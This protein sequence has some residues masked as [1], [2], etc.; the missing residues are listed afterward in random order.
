MEQIHRNKNTFL[1]PF[2]LRVCVPLSPVRIE[3]MKLG[4]SDSPS[5]REGERGRHRDYGRLHNAA[6]AAIAIAVPGGAVG[7]VGWL[8]QIGSRPHSLTNGH[9][10]AYHCHHHAGLLHGHLRTAMYKETK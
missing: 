6:F 2:N 10:D 7:P 9:F 3:L 1:P 8:V 5:V 4:A